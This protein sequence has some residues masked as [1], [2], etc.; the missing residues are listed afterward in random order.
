MIGRYQLNNIDTSMHTHAHY[1]YIYIYIYNERERERER[2]RGREKCN[3]DF[4]KV[5]FG[6]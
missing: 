1:I 2:E 4:L 3:M 6:L 5:N